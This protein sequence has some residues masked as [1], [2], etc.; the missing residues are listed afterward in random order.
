MK[1]KS[2]KTPATLA[3]FWTQKSRMFIGLKPLKPWNDEMPIFS[4]CF[5]RL[6]LLVIISFKASAA[7]AGL[8]HYEIDFHQ[9]DFSYGIRPLSGGFDIESSAIIPNSYYFPGAGTV[10]NLSVTLSSG[11]QTNILTEV[12]YVADATKPLYIKGGSGASYSGNIMIRTNEHGDVVDLYTNLFPNIPVPLDNPNDPFTFLEIY[13][14]GYVELFGYHFINTSNHPISNGKIGVA[15][16]VPLPAT[17][18][19]FGS[20]VLGIVASK[21]TRLVRMLSL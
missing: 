3:E 1:I 11:A 17:I 21:K 6:A 9:V 2:H 13:D 7:Q 8:I 15:S 4:T 20:V 12:T 10:K 19:L 5:V 16:P 18:W 14:G